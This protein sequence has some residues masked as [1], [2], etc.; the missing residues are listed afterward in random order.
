MVSDTA[1]AAAA[2]AAGTPVQPPPVSP[3]SAAPDSQAPLWRAFV[4]FLAP[5]L[6]SNILQ[7]LSGTLNNVYLGQMLGVKALAAVSS[8]F[9]VLFS[10][11]LSTLAW[12][13]ALR[14]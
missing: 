9:P 5:M 13:R 14:C 10:L 1:P 2:A 4:V 7:S 11:L 12:A 6:L 8:F 3:G